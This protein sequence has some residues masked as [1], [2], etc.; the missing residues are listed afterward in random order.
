MVFTFSN[1]K[2]Y[3]VPYLTTNKSDVSVGDCHI[4]EINRG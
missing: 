3:T 2:K 4:L 1:Y